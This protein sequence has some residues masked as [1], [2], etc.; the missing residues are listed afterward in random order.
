MR[1]RTLLL[2]VLSVQCISYLSAQSKFYIQANSGYSMSL[3]SQP[4]GLK[5][6]FNMNSN[7]N[8]RTSSFS[9]VNSSLGSGF[10]GGLFA[11]YIIN[12]FMAV[13]VGVNYINSAS[14]QYSE[15]V[16]YLDNELMSRRTYSTSAKIINISPGIRLFKSVNSINLDL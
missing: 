4:I 8:S 12:D 9:V 2:V 16:F 13:E 11:G 1:K 3:F 14:K 6:T 5:T 15:E 10:N 7:D